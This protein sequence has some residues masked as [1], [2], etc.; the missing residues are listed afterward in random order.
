MAGDIFLIF[1]G[2]FFGVNAVTRQKE[3]FQRLPL[4]VSGAVSTPFEE[5]AGSAQEK[6]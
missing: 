4:V 1:R 3:G 2:L 5:H 6:P